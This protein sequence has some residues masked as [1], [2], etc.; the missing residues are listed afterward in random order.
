MPSDPHR[1]FLF[2]FFPSVIPGS[3]YI[4]LEIL[5]SV[6]RK[7]SLFSQPI[8]LLNYLKLVLD[9]FC[10]INFEERNSA[11]MA[12]WNTRL[13]LSYVR[14]DLFQTWYDARHNWALQFDSSLNELAVRSRSQ[15]HWKAELVQSLCWKV[16]WSNSDVH[17]ECVGKMTVTVNI[18]HL[19]IC[20]SCFSLSLSLSLS[21]SKYSCSAPTPPTPPPP[22]PPIL[23]HWLM[24]LDCSVRCP[25]W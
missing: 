25:A 7:F 4:F 9:F 8:G 10:T 24:D 23:L 20:S 18:V 3:V 16:A 1:N 12:L 2:L 22:P 17:D 19:S 13:T 15:D 5:R 21:L 6:W 11:D 14:T